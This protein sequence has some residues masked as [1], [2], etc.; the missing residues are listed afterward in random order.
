MIPI[1]VEAL[2]TIPKIMVKGLEDEDHPNLGI[3]KISQYSFGDLLSL[4]L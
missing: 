2:E 3:I 1:V 4:N